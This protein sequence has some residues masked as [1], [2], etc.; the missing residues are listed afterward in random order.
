M[1]QNNWNRSRVSS[2]VITPE[3]IMLIKIEICH[4]DL[5]QISY[6]VPTW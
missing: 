6:C 4:E 2:N 3:E 5:F 1:V